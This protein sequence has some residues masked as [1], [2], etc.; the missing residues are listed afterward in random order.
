MMLNRVIFKNKVYY[1]V[2]DLAELFSV[3]TYR[4]RKAIKTQ[5]I[6]AKPLKGF[7]RVL[8]VQEENVAKIVMNNQAKT[9]KT[10]FN[11]NPVQETKTIETEKTPSKKTKS[12]SKN[13]KKPASKG[14]KVTEEIVN[15]EVC[16][17]KD[18]QTVKVKTEQVTEAQPKVD[19][20]QKECDELKKEINELR[21]KYAK[22][23]V[24]EKY[25]EIYMA[26]IGDGELDE[27]MTDNLDTVRQ[28]IEMLKLELGET[29]AQADLSVEYEQMPAF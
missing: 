1:K 9:L 5:K 10:E 11:E 19:E 8:F 25:N 16:P 21:L 27:V 3:S 4:M 29:N 28:F 15:A 20:H 12:K 13:R 23:C 24:S 14:K 6:T 22:K 2:A 17:V 18:E 7:G 26:Y